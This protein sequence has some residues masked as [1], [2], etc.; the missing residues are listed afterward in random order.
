MDLLYLGDFDIHQWFMGRTGNP[1]V[2]LAIH[3]P[4]YSTWVILSVTSGFE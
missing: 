4:I 1:V 2:V 3:E